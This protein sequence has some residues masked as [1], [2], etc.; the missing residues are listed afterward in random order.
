[1][2]WA[3]AGCALV[4]A[5][6][7]AWLAHRTQAVWPD[8]WIDPLIRVRPGTGKS[9]KA[10][11]S[12]GDPAWS[13]GCCV[14]LVAACVAARRYRAALLAALAVPVAS[15]LTEFALKPLIGRT[16][17]GYLAFPSGHVTAVSA[18]AVALVVLLVGPSRPPL[19]AAARWAAGVLAVAVVAA[20]AVAMVALTDHYA[21][22]TVGGA[23]VGTGTA[24][25][26]ALAIDAAAGALARHRERSASDQ[27]AA[28]PV[29]D[30]TADRA[31]QDR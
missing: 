21:T 15:A 17:V 3:V 26:M 7:G 28:A 27:R 22:D 29:G 23:A 5:V 8:T 18:L 14:I 10:L 24:L 20:V 9:A 6:M 12:I 13:T 16:I 30:L 2:A 19:P 25:A 1:V 31:G 4:M 11:R